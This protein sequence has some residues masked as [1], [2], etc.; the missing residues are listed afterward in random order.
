VDAKAIFGL[1]SEGV[2]VVDHSGRIVLVNRRVKEI[3]GYGADEMLGRPLDILLPEKFHR[4]HA[5]AIESFFKNPRARSMGH[6]RDLVAKR[7]NGETFPVEVG[8]CAFNVGHCELSIA[9][10]ADISVRKKMEMELKAR[11]AEL[12]AFAHTVAHD[13]SG[14]LT[15]IVG[16]SESLADSYETLSPQEIKNDLLSIAKA[17]LKMGDIIKSLLLF[18]SIR[19]EDVVVSE[20]DMGA[21]VKEVLHRLHYV[22]QERE[23]EVVVP[24]HF[25]RALGVAAWVEEVW[26]N[27]ISNGLKYGGNP[28]RLVLGGESTEA[29][30]VRFWVSDNG[31][32]IPQ[33]KLPKIFAPL[34]QVNGTSLAGYGLG[35]SIVQ[36]IV[37]KLDGKVDAQSQPGCGS[38]F[39]FTLKAP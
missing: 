16:L 19:K 36:R 7:K 9:I 13:L 2:V 14:A 17:G 32:G 22:I 5:L 25:P 30:E 6:G 27:Y 33:E 23:A 15:P 12:D 3:F 20:L 4:S 34:Y 38:T 18:A 37:D 35:L 10:V 31:A 24:E 8:L 21:I 26:Y 39:S 11:N 1:L 28:P 29:G